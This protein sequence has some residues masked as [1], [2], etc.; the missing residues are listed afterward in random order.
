MIRGMAFSDRNENSATRSANFSS[1][2]Q[3]SV[4]GRTV[5]GDL[6]DLGREKHGV[7]RGCRPQQ[8]DRVLRSDCARRAIF[9]C[10]FHQVV[11]CCP[12][13]MAI[14]QRA[15]DPAVQNSLERFVFFLR[16]PLGDDFAVFGETMNVQAIW[17]CRTAAEANVSRRIFFLKRLRVHPKCILP[18][19]LP[20]NLNLLVARERREQRRSR[21]RLFCRSG[22][23]PQRW[24]DVE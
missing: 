22:I 20:L 9:A 2:T 10:A 4:N 12:V 13:A 24:P 21:G 7:V 17:I 8:V 16:F 3:C 19:P 5:I 23:R 6:N 1:G 15:D 14:E 11:C 18:L